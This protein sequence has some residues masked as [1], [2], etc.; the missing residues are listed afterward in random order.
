M[1]LF[2]YSYFIV[3]F[4]FLANLS[5]YTIA[6]IGIDRYIRTKYYTNFRAIWTT[7]VVTSLICIG[8][9][10][11]LFQAITLSVALALQKGEAISTR[12]ML[13]FCFFVTPYVIALNLVRYIDQDKLN[14]NHKSILQFTFCFSIIFLMVIPS[15][16]LLFFNNKR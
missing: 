14:D 2:R 6:I 10:L 7:K 4:R 1:Q 11:S 3:C 9:L 12:I 13:L 5:S 15:I 16:M 8:C